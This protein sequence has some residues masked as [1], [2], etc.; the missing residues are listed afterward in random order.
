[1]LPVFTFALRLL[2][3]SPR[4]LRSPVARR[5]GASHT[6]GCWRRRRRRVLFARL[7][8]RL[9]LQ[10]LFATFD[11][12]SEACGRIAGQVASL[13]GKLIPAR[14]AGA[15]LALLEAAEGVELFGR[16]DAPDSEFRERAQAHDGGLCCADLA[17][18]FFDDALVGV[19]GIDG[20]IER[21]AGFAETRAK[22]AALRF[23]LKPDRGD[24]LTLF[25]CQIQDTEQTGHVRAAPTCV[26]LTP[27]PR[28]PRGRVLILRTHVNGGDAR[29]QKQREQDGGRGK[30]KLGHAQCLV[31]LFILSRRRVVSYRGASF[32][33]A[34]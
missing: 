33:G 17:H 6:R 34:F 12:V 25:G 18:A 13:P 32:A 24:P 8:L 20:F 22:Q 3:L 7:A 14:A 15:G 5:S 4:R 29:R 31:E 16:E 19:G 2:P 1:M 26:Q 30:S 27:R 11:V 21:A 10:L 23:G 28:P 9:L